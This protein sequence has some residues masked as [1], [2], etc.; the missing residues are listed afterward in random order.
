MIK[1]SESQITINGLLQQLP[2]TI[3]WKDKNSVYLGCSEH[4]VQLAGCQSI[5]DIVGKTDYDLAWAD[6]A[7]ALINND[8][9]VM[10]S[11][12]TQIFP[13]SLLVDKG[14]LE[15]SFTIKAP[16]RDEH[17]EIIGVL[18]VSNFLTGMSEFLGIPM[19]KVTADAIISQIESAYLQRLYQDISGC[20]AKS[21]LTALQYGKKVRD[22]IENLISLLPVQ[23]FWMDCDGVYKGVNQAVVDFLGLKD[24]HELIGKTAAYFT[25]K[26]PTETLARI[27]EQNKNIV[28]TGEPVSS[29]LT[30][31]NKDGKE[32]CCVVN[33]MPI[34]DSETN[35]VIG[36]LG[37]ATDITERKRME[38]EL[39]QAK[40]QTERVYQAESDYLHNLYR[41]ISGQQMPQGATAEKTA[42]KIWHYIENL[43]YQVP[44][45][46]FWMDKEGRYLGGNDT[47]ERVIHLKE[48]G[49]MIGKTNEEL[50]W[51]D[52]IEQINRNNKQVLE[53]G[54]MKIFEEYYRDAENRLAYYLSHKAPIRDNET[55]EVIG[56]IGASLDITERK[57]MEQELGQA[58]ERS[59]AA[60][61]AKSHFL[62]NMR[63]DIRTPL[64][65]MVG[66]ARILKKLED[67]PEKME[68]IDGILDCSESLL[69]MVTDMLEYDTLSA[70]ERA[71]QLEPVRI[72]K[73][74]KDVFL[75]LGMLAKRKGIDLQLNIADD[76]P[77][78]IL[79]D[80][81]RMQRILLNLISNAIKFTDKGHVALNIAVKY[82]DMKSIALNIAVHDT[83]IGIPEDKHDSIFGK[84]VRLEVN[85]NKQA[86]DGLGLSI[87]H[88][89][90]TEL[91]GSIAVSSTPG[92]GSTFYLTVPCRV[93]VTQKE[94]A[95]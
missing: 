65:C 26:Q 59:E 91:K 58:K 60:S 56:L 28:R 47:I 51:P 36:I 89:Y 90:V 25:D 41:N 49:G 95:L 57:R 70:K 84:F 40:E 6:V 75:M 46:L 53:S 73:L 13:E 68:F 22:Y 63:H 10:L 54:E 43:L 52:M 94:E 87:V 80:S 86:G 12:K 62:S 79:M 2:T 50:L 66:S 71:I 7:Q 21:N 55:G 85:N 9:E 5:D 93:T 11:G 39:Q 61:F 76:V 15:V 81:Y 64:S 88:Q 78:R 19:P 31:I 24:K 18:G 17:G 67:D 30:G 44:V 23:V 16:L 8:K 3:F 83:G 29:E 72:K 74:A 77:E 38:K 4:M 33:K 37:V 32:I 69:S 35:E 34:R 1:G 14:E 48:K 42:Q 92:E 82:Q 20:T 27:Q 45:G